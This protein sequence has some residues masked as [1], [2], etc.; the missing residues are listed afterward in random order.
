[1][2]QRH[3]P[4]AALRHRDYRCLLAGSICATVGAEVTAVTV[5]WELYERTGEAWLLGMTGLAIFLPVLLLSLPAG[6]TA[7]RFSRKRVLQCAVLT[8]FLAVVG[9]AVL[10][11]TQ[12][13]VSLIFACLVL[14]GCGRAFSMPSRASLV[15]L[16]VPVEHLGNAVTWNSSG[17]QIANVTGP[18][19]GGLVIALTGRAAPAYLVAAGFLLAC[20]L[21]LSPIRP[22]P[23]ARSPEP[24]SLNSLL[25]GVRFIWRSEFLLAAITLDM[26]AVLLGGATALLPI[27][28]K[29]VLYIGPTG[30]G[31]LRGAPAFGAL[32][33]AMVLA[34]HP[35]R[36]PGRALL[37]SVAGF[38][39][40]TIVFGLSREPVLSFAMLA[41]AGA[42]DNISV[43][44]RGTLLQVLTPDD[45]RGRVSAVNAVFISSSNEL[46]A[47]ESGVTAEWMGPVVAV[48]FGG[49][50]TVVV[51][52]AALFRWPALLTL[53]PLRPPTAVEPPP[54]DLPTPT[55]DGTP[56]GERPERDRVESPLPP[57]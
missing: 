6:H 2:T 17:F 31:W 26:F 44:I 55:P 21:L 35:P 46:G 48:V 50:G 15:P 53:G 23:A 54:G 19:L 52:L 43:V 10:S 14:A 8:I 38:G 4:Y 32:L 56:T 9:L 24:R 51:V 5:G 25:A 36:R 29:D 28:A 16:V 33:M 39:V 34:Y 47:F 22:R 41:L 11:L 45:M 7:D 27:F 37:A 49:V 3:D 40:A 20:V 18:A 57:V 12:G 1:M 13:P 30:L 42:L